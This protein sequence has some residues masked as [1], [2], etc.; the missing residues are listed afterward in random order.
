MINIPAKANERI[1]KNLKKFQKIVTAA[2]DNDI[3]EADTVSIIK[4]I[5]CEI[6]GF[7]KYSEITS[8]Y[9]VKRT[10]C[11]LAIKKDGSPY[12]LIE[13]KAV[14]LTLK[15]DHTK[16]ALDYGSNA[17]IDWIILTNAAHW[18]IYKVVFSK[19]IQSELVY[20]FCFE[21]LN[22]RKAS[23]IEMLYYLSKEAAT[24]SV[25]KGLLDEYRE[26]K[27]LLSKYLIGQVLLTDEIA[28]AVKKVLK[29]IAPASKVNL[30]DIKPVL[31][32]EVIKREILEEERTAEIKKKIQK[33]LKP[34]QKS[35]PKAGNDS[36]S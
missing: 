9:A 26:Q 32:N 34:T 35:S 17:G 7:D 25:V 33:A 6:L 14:G 20:E 31:E 15:D 19:P 1:T 2:K 4:D 21:D 30:D 29:K 16:Q 24:K 18:K 5:L 28:D 27:Q 10:F 12:I 3:N 36:A 23:D 22:P 13:V 8:E 11:D